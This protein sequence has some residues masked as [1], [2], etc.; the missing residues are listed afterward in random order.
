MRIG[1]TYLGVSSAGYVYM[2]VGIVLSQAMAGAGETKPA[3][4]DRVP[5]ATSCSGCPLVWVVASHADALGG[6][7]ALWIAVL[8][9]HLAVAVAYVVW[10]RRGSWA[11]TGRLR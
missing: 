10:F 8:A 7:R 3:L 11:D 1:R 5:R 2:A 4:V 6:L 9:T